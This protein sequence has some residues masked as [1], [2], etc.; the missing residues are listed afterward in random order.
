MSTTIIE[1]KEKLSS[2]FP[3][4]RS[5]FLGLSA[6][7]TVLVRDDLNQPAE[8]CLLPDVLK[9]NNITASAT[10]IR[11]TLLETTWSVGEF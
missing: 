3:Q 6:C 11:K 9:N 7:H 4:F 2:F 10:V 1:Q 5:F 8:R